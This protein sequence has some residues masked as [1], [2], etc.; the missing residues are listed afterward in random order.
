MTTSKKVASDAARALDNPKS[1]KVVKELAASDLAQAKRK[2]KKKK[3][4]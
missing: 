1:S 3:K 2:K 4:R